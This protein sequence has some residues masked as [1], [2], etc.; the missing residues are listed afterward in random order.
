MKISAVLIITPTYG[1]RETLEIKSCGSG[2]GGKSIWA[3]D[4]AEK[5]VQLSADEFQTIGCLLK[6]IENING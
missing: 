4:T 6:T 1:G 5:R 3:I 2:T